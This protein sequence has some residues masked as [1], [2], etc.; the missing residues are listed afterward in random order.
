[1]KL[2]SKLIAFSKFK[3]ESVE[4]DLRVA[5]ISKNNILLHPADESLHAFCISTKTIDLLVNNEEDL[6]EEDVLILDT[7]KLKKSECFLA[8]INTAK[9]QNMSSLYKHYIA[10]HQKRKKEERNIIN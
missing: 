10:D 6:Q 5:K 2:F 1:M 3:G 4:I 7:E 8:C 9:K